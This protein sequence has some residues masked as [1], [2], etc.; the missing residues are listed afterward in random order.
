MLLF[1]SE[2][3]VQNWCKQW[4]LPLGATL[5]LNQ[6]WQLAIAWFKPDRR[7][8]DW[9]RY[10]VEEAQDIFTKIGLTSPFWNLSE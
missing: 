4:N 8:P 2:E 1:R 10:S 5:T 9:K 3:H 6:I 7:N